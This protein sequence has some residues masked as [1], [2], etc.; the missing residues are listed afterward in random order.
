L[1]KFEGVQVIVQV[2]LKGYEKWRFSAILALFLK[3]QDTISVTME[4]DRNSYAVY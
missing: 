3:R 4:D 2:K 1:E